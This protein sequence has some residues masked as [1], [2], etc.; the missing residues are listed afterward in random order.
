MKAL[1]LGGGSMKGAFQVGAV[2]AALEEGFEP[3]MIYGISVGALNATYLVNAAGKN[4]HEKVPLDWPAI[5]HQLMSFW[6]RNITHPHD[7]AHLRSRVSMGFNTL[8]SRFE[9]LLDP[10]PLHNLIRANVDPFLIRSSPVKIKVGAVNVTHG[11]IV[12]ASPEEEFFMDYVRASSSLPMLMPAVPIG[13][14]N[15]MF[16]DG[17]L[18]IVAPIHRAIMDGAKEIILVACHSKDL[19]TR[20]NFSP[21]NLISLIER[22]KDVTVNQIVNNDIEWAENY[23][24][25]SALRGN[26]IK[27]TVIRPATP[28][29]LDLQRFTS[30]DITRLILEGYQVGLETLR[31]AKVATEK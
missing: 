22:V 1:V 10:S 15:D 5:G 21:Q 23:A 16:L 24:E 27:L 3:E 30:E 2:K 28:L 14:K 8:M 19:Y 4:A 26:P 13:T 9:G 12:F 18:R 6:I 31:R 11:N 25:H 29:L 20:E 17:G 7:V